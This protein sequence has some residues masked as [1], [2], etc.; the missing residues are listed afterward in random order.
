MQGKISTVLLLLCC[1][2]VAS[3]KKDNTYR[4]AVP[5]DTYAGTVYEYLQSQPGNFKNVLLMLEKGGLA[6]VLKKDT[7]TVFAPTD[8][9]LNAALEAYNV[10]LKTL[11]SPPVTLNDI[12]SSTWRCVLANYLFKGN[13]EMESFAGQDGRTLTSMG[14]RAMD[15][16]LVQRPAAGA[17]GL[18]S[19]VVRL[20]SMNGSRFIKYWLS[21]FATT[22]DIHATNGMVYILESKHVVGFNTFV[23][24]A[25]AYQ[26]LYSEEKTFA[27]GAVTLGNGV[28][29][30]WNFYPKKLKA[31]DANTVETEA[32]NKLADDYR[33]LLTI[34]ADNKITVS[35][36]PG[37]ANAT[38]KNNGL[39]LFDPIGQTYTLNYSYKDSNDKDCTVTEVI[40]YIAIREQ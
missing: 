34:H 27:D 14:L 13:W 30:L 17:A 36:A 18:G 1:V 6:T 16:R 8:Q 25:A 21:T 12:D 26:N 19:E 7:V 28:V 38:I 9:S 15:I 40:R 20:S 10:Y 24:K 29:N 22:S 23:T 2:V 32:A 33:M 4:A 37:S 5:E 3:C 11:S 39:C 35:S 31:I